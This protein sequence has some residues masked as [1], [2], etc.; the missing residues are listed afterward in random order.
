MHKNLAILEIKKKSNYGDYLA[1][2]LQC[3]NFGGGAILWA[4]L[5]AI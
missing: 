3:W 4:Q 2:F 1:I 5:L